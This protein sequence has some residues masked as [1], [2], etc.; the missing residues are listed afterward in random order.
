MSR[1]KTSIMVSA[2]RVNM[3]FVV[4][5]HNDNIVARGSKY[6]SLVKKLM[7]NQSEQTHMIGHLNVISRISVRTK[8]V[9]SQDSE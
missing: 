3:M 7:K 2:K 4:E 8:I 1:N 6:S 5:Q 9:S